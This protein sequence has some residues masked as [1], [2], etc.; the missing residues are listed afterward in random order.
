MPLFFALL[1]LVS[2]S[3]LLVGRWLMRGAHCDVDRIELFVSG[4][5]IANHYRPLERLLLQTDW[6]YLSRQPGMTSA[7]IR[8]FR[9]QRRKLFRQYLSSLIGDFSAIC[10][11]IKA[12]MVQSSEDRPDLSRSLSRA[13]TAFYMAIVGIHLRLLVH[14]VGFPSITI[15]VG[16]LTRALEAI[17]AQARMLQL[18]SEPTFA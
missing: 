4:E 7:R 12:L 3:A 11:L 8:Q 18:S 6:Q 14:A 17:S 5:P 10:M 15:E 16:D 9:T 1:L 13:K 2:L